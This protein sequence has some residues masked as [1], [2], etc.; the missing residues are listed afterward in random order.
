MGGLA[1]GFSY[2]DVL[3]D[4][5]WLKKVMA[6]GRS[7]RTPR[8]ASQRRI[9][10]H[11]HHLHHHRHRTQTQTT[12]RQT[13]TGAPLLR[14]RIISVI[15]RPRQLAITCCQQSFNVLIST[16]TLFLHTPSGT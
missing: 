12:I 4:G 16:S 10:P 2:D 11:L 6:S 1:K 15:G 8:V 7:M 14:G 9:H 5:R 3:T 13:T